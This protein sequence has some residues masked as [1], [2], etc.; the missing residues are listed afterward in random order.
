MVV[1]FTR[2]FVHKDSGWGLKDYARALGQG[3]LSHPSASPFS[4]FFHFPVILRLRLAF[5]QSEGSSSMSS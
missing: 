1:T 4:A 5:K 2:I 3:H